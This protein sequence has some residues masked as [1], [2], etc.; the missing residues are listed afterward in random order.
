MSLKKRIG[1]T[2]VSAVCEDCGKSFEDYKNGQ[3]LAAKHAKD[4]KHRVGGEIVIM[5]EYDGRGN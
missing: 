5:F 1:V 4:K 3:A 2:S